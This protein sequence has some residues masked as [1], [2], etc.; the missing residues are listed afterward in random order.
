MLV[1]L[2][3][4]GKYVVVVGGGLE[5][6]RKTSDFLE[7]GAH[8]L[9]VSESFSEGI[10]TLHDQGKIQ[11]QQKKVY[12]AQAFFDQLIPKPDLLVAVTSNPDLNAALVSYAKSVGCMVYAPQD[13]RASDF[14]LP[15]TAK[16]GDVRIAISTSGKSP[17][18]ASVLRKRIEQT[19]LPE[20]LL[21]IKLQD[22][23]RRLLK[24][25]F[26]DQRLRRKV[27]YDIIQDSAV[28]ALLQQGNFDGAKEKATQIAEAQITLKEIPK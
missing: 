23:M 8:I 5:S 18:M 21:Q 20:D 24:A 13:P 28:Q 26:S 12:D 3:V 2:K 17:A 4:D 7:A 27:L 15:A 19:I 25:K 22:Q 14:N 9:V 6:Y 10:A 11:L 1:D 16:V